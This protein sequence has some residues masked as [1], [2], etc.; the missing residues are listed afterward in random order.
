[1]IKGVEFP[2]R[3][4]QR[5][6]PVGEVMPAQY[7]FVHFDQDWFVN[8]LMPWQNKVSPKQKLQ[9]D[10]SVTIQVHLPSDFTSISLY[11]VACDGTQTALSGDPS[12]YISNIELPGNTY[13]DHGAIAPVQLTT[14]Q[15]R[16]VTGEVLSVGAWYF[17]VRAVIDG[18]T[19]EY[20]SEP[21]DV[22]E[23]WPQT[24]L[25]AYG[26]SR[27]EYDV[28]FQLN[29]RFCIR[30]DGYIQ[31]KA[32]TRE[33][34][35]F[36]NERQSQRQ[37][38]SYSSRAFNLCLGSA[39][40]P[41][42]EYDIDK[43]RAIMDLDN[44]SFDGKRFL[45]SGDGEFTVTDY[46]YNAVKPLTI[47]IVEY[48]PEDAGKYYKPNTIDLYELG[49][50][51]YIISR[52][53]I[54]GTGGSIMLTELREIF[55]SGD[56]TVLVGYLNTT[57]A[58][59]YGQT[60]TYSNTGT[61]IVYTNGPGEDYSTTLSTVYRPLRIGV[62]SS[63][64]KTLASFSMNGGF[65]NETIVS[66]WE[67]S[68]VTTNTYFPERFEVSGAFTVSKDL[69]DLGDYFIYIYTNDFLT[70]LLYGTTA[71]PVPYLIDG[72]VSS[73]MQTFRIRFAAI[74]DLD[75]SFLRRASFYLQSMD[76][77][78]GEID[79]ITTT[80]WDSLDAGEWQNLSNIA[81]DNNSLD[82]A[83]QDDLYNEF[84]SKVG[85]LY[86]TAGTI[87]SSSQSPASAP[88]GA[89]SGSRVFLIS[90]GWTLIF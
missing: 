87:N 13:D 19:L 51:P 68:F 63:S 35:T 44:L 77:S 2:I 17:L 84:Y 81:F 88:T 24:L 8:T 69:S 32:P 22:R 53:M 62:T 6:V 11:K 10:Q 14:Y 37:L 65:A 4:S 67:D 23:D 25:I 30:L 86:L 58:V 48:Y 89:S 3:N 31:N 61:K 75:F 12:V 20:I 52:L 49:T 79:T 28:V 70:Q 83:A 33:T 43:I 7:H 82:D 40:E 45:M 46:K 27:N 60:G 29:P 71:R 57:V 39:L 36:T 18:D 38:E 66:V 74:S 9:L 41:I 16:F 72:Q 26:H 90:K 78:R 59:I 56:E 42:P 76:F 64:G 47:P 34:T 73:I 15:W 1:M 85:S 80:A 21:N 5:F 54:T 50:Y 55:N